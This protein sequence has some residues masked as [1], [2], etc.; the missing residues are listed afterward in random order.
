MFIAAA[1]EN[2]PAQLRERT[3]TRFNVSGTSPLLLTA[4]KGFWFGD[5]KHVT[6]NGVNN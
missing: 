4:P 6:P 1:V 3:G 2:P 5:H